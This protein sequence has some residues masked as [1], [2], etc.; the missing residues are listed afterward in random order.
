MGAAAAAAG[1]DIVEPAMGAVKAAEE[2]PASPEA[3][4]AETPASDGVTTWLLLATEAGAG[5]TREGSEDTAD[6]QNM[7]LSSSHV[8]CT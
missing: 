6:S 3:A 5:G 8:A 4:A 1:K 7:V 2:P